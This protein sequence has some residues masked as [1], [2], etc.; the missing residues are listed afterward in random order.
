MSVPASETPAASSVGPY[1]SLRE[2][3]HALEARGKLLR[4]PEMDQDRF[5]ATA[6]AYRLIERMGYDKA[7]AFLIEKIKIDGQWMDGPILGNLYGAWDDEGLPFGVEPLGDDP[8]TLFQAV[9]AHMETRMDD[10][11]AWKTIPPIE[12]EDAASAPCK[13]VILTGNDIDVEQ[14]PWLR[15]NPA[16]AGRYINMGNVILQDAELGNNVGTYRCQVKGKT[17]IGMNPEPGQHGWRLLMGMKRRGDTSAPCAVALGADP[18]IF[19]ASSTKM[20][21]FQEDEMALAGG[22]RGKPIELVRCET[23]DILVPAHAEMIIEGSIPLDERE[24]EGP[25]GEM[26]GYLGPEKPDNFF[27]N[28]T[29]ITHRR[30]PWFVNSFTGIT[31]DM[32]KGPQ[33]AGEF[34]RYKRLIPNLVAIYSLRGASGVVALSIDKRFPGEGMAAGQSVVANTALNKVV[35]VVDKDIDILDPLALLHAIGARWQPATA[36]LM[37]PQTQMMMPDPSRPTTGLS[38]KFVIDATRQLPAEG[39]PNT[40]PAVSK[41]LLEQGCPEA[42][43]LVDGKWAEYWRGSEK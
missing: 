27:I 40:W 15:V 41:V 30:N 4:I 34:K 7:P 33:T 19:S 28:I 11:G 36:S 5:E 2:F 21:G 43:E 32:P 22:L 42:F 18:V 25:Y 29:A 1:D 10:S 3:V 17:K 24:D 23:N 38:S 26:Y 12:V 13:E 35:I 8:P 39:G 31:A 9:L 20:A 6:F 37:I 14:F 16:D